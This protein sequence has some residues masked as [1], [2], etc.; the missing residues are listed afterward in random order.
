LSRP[1]RQFPSPLLGCLGDLERQKNL[2][3]H[4]R[5]LGLLLYRRRTQWRTAV[6]AAV[7]AVLYISCDRYWLDMYRTFRLDLQTWYSILLRGNTSTSRRLNIFFTSRRCGGS[8]L[9]IRFDCKFILF[10]EIGAF[11]IHS[12]N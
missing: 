2:R 7:T 3:P 1:R 5:T 8:K 9:N 12:E 4:S 6:D 11:I 10:S